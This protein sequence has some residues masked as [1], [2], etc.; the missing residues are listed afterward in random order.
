MLRKIHVQLDAIGQNGG[1]VGVS[2]GAEDGLG[3]TPMGAMTPPTGGA[4]TPLSDAGHQLRTPPSKNLDA[5]HDEDA[6][7]RFWASL[8]ILGLGS[9][10]GQAA[11]V[12]QEQLSLA[13][14]EEPTSFREAEQ[15]ISWR[16]PMHEEISSIEENHTWKLV[17]QLAGYQPIWLKWVFKLKKDAKGVIV[18]HKARLV[19][20]GYA[21]K[22]GIDFDEVFAP[23]ARL[24]SVRLL[25][26]IAAQEGWMVHHLNVKSTF[27]NGELEGR[28]VCTPTTWLWEGRA[29]PQSLQAQ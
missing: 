17:D 11:W 25:L 12:V 29:R 27:L 15:S 24:D 5:D 28:S 18:K 7:L 8:D 20:K 19:A 26:V 9:P 13:A 14:G 6:P 3:S 2:Q 21:Q 4:G 10:P 22:A 23:V 1:D 16:K